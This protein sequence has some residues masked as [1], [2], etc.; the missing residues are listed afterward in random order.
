MTVDAGAQLRKG[1]VEF[2]IL[3]LLEREAMYGWQLSQQLIERGGFIASIGTLYPVLGRLRAK[4]WVS[5]YEETS[6]SGPSRRYYELTELGRRSLSDFRSQWA[7][8]SH[9]VDD[10]MERKGTT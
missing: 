3:A 8:F 2:A 4:E 5:T 10:L 9:S 6:E 7:V 1:V